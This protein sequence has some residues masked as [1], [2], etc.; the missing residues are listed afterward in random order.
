M[1][2]FAM[3]RQHTCCFEYLTQMSEESLFILQSHKREVQFIQNCVW[4]NHNQ[5][6]TEILKLLI[7][8]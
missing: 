2:E 1:R 6:M 8:E 3:M 4:Y 5:L 7:S